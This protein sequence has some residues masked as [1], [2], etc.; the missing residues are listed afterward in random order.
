MILGLI[1]DIHFKGTISTPTYENKVLPF[2]SLN[3]MS[4]IRLKVLVLLF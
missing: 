1:I 2:Y 3:N 4:F